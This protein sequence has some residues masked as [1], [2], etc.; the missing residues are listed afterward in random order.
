MK[1]NWTEPCTERERERNK[2]DIKYII[3]NVNQNTAMRVMYVNEKVNK[4]NMIE[5]KQNLLQ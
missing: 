1:L 5:M 4:I 3:M 2:Q